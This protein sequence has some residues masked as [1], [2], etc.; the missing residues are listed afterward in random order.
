[1]SAVGQ[2]AAFAAGAPPSLG[3][4]VGQAAPADYVA[5]PTLRF[6]LS[7]EAAEGQVVR[8]ILLDVQI[9]IAARRRPYGGEEVDRLLELFGTPERWA[10]TL[11]T[12][13]W[14]RTNVIVPPF[15]G[16][17][18]IDLLVPCSYDLEL[19]A[20]RYFAAL[21]EGEVP[22]EFLFSGTVFYSTPGGALQTA[23]IPWEHEVEHRLPIAT[24]RATMDRHFPGAAWLRLGRESFDRLSAYKARHAFESWDVT[25]EALLAKAGSADG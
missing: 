14:M 10:T 5:V 21:A 18:A 23:R 25:I 12:L 3:F 13:L 22:L 4:A 2:P 24:W 19:T 17:T 6:P 16:S 15:T 8:S 1:V 11:R 9:Q 20:S 7:I